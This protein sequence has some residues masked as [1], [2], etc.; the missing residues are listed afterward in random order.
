[1]KFSAKRVGVLGI[2]A[3][4]LA[5]GLWM[6]GSCLSSKHAVARYKEK[7]R[8]AGEKLTIAELVPPPMPPESNSA[9]VLLR[10]ARLN[11]ASTC[12]DTNQPPSMRMVAPGKAMIGWQQ[13]DIL[14]FHW[15]TNSWEEAEA[16][17]AQ[18]ADAL[19]GF[20]QI[21]EQPNLDFGLA[22]QQGLTLLLPHLSPLKAA[23]QRLSASALIHLHR[24]DV[25]AAVTDIRA[26]LA[27]VKS[28]AEERLLISQLVRIAIA[29]ITVSANWELLQATNLTDVQLATLQRDWMELD[30]LRPAEYALTMERAFAQETIAQMRSSSAKFRQATGPLSSI[31][32]GSSP[33]PPRDI[34]EF[35]QWLWEG[36]RM[37]GKEFMWRTAWSYPDELRSLRAQQVMLETVR[38]AETNGCFR[39]ATIQQKQKLEGLGFKLEAEGEDGQLI[40]SDELDFR[41][42]FSSSVPAFGR[43]I[44]RLVSAEAARQLTVTAIALKRHQ[45]RHGNCPPNLAALVP[46]LLPAVPKDPVDGQPLRYRRNDDGTFLLYSVGSDGK[47]DGGDAR[48]LNK[49]SPSLTWYRGR[50]WVWPQAA[51]PEEVKAYY[52]QLAK[53]HGGR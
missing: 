35:A 52:Q 53:K 25:T 27:L 49:E 3:V 5:F 50:D 13:P 45:L 22:Y 19:E 10:A 34:K 41:S 17:L 15:A 18:Y 7:L 48:P 6:G 26:M 16:A 42:L 9:G 33:T 40:D 31:G 4:V 39:E 20:H 43:T 37:A 28:S 29:Q 14:D 46:D 21:I 32:S 23:A 51:T 12:V 38:L 30:F 8:A 24:G 1:M 36:T 44:D 11:N 2:A 47:D